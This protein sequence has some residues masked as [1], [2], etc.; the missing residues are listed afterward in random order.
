M[1]RSRNPLDVR[2]HFAQ[3]LLI[4]EALDRL[5]GIL[6]QRASGWSQKLQIAGENPRVI[7]LSLPGAMRQALHEKASFRGCHYQELVRQHG[8]PRYERVLGTEELRGADNSLVLVVSVDEWNLSPVDQSWAFGNSVI[9]HVCKTAIQGTDAV[10]WTRNTFEQ[11]CALLSPVWGHAEFSAEYFAKNVSTEDGG[12]EAIG[13]DV[14]KHLPGIYWLNFF[15]APYVDLIGR[16]RLLTAPCLEAKA[17]DSGVLL[18]LASSPQEWEHSTYKQTEERVLDHLGRQYFF[19]RNAP[20]R[21][22]TAPKFPLPLQPAA[23]GD[24]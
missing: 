9:L 11:L 10:R 23:R 21:P 6:R 19:C 14:S 8:R 18:A 15:G 3:S 7:E 13:T 16:E 17:A 5:Q 4:G 1:K 2:L 24:R 20:T 22:T 12:L